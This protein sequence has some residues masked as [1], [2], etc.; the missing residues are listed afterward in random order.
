M[1]IPT[2]SIGSIPRPPQLL[3]AMASVQA[4]KITPEALNDAYTEALK[5]TIARFEQ[6]GSPSSQTAS[7]RSPALR[8]TH[9]PA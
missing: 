5:D 7:N 6:T 1:A 9:S 3:Q 8:P 4:G 2:E